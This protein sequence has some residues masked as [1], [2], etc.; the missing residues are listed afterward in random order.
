MR[1]AEV[2]APPLFRDHDGEAAVRREI[3]VIGIVDP[4]RR[5]GF[6]GGGVDRRETAGGP[7]AAGARDPQGLE[8][9]GRHDVLGMEADREVVEHLQRGWVDHVDIARS[10]VR[11]IDPRQRARD[12]GAEVVRADLAV[13]IVAVGHRR[14]ARIGFRRLREGAARHQKCQRQAYAR[15]AAE[16]VRV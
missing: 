2:E 3:E 6:A 10:D 9:V 1:I 12:R 15:C 14:H 11:H 13:D 16:Q 5:T 7:A 8:V 4:D